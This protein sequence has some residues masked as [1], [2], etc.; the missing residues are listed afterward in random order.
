MHDEE[1]VGLAL[2]AIED[3]MSIREAARFC[4]AS[5]ESVRLWAKGRLP[6]ERRCPP[7]RSSAKPPRQPARM[8]SP[9]HEEVSPVDDDERAAYEA[10]MLENQLLRAVLADLKAGGWDPA[11]IS[12][13]RKTELGER[14]R[15]ATGLPLRAITAFLRISK[16][17]YE[18]HRARLGKVGIRDAIAD[19]VER[20][21]AEEGRSARG[22]RFVHA[23]LASE[24]GRPISEKIVRDVMRERGLEVVY[25]RTARKHSSYAGETDAGA[26][27]LPYD[28]ATGRHD[29]R[30]GAPNEKWASDVTEFNPTGDYRAFLSPVIDL[31]D[32]KPI[33]W[34]I[35]EHP[36]SKLA[37]SSLLAACATLSEGQRPFCHTDRGSLYRSNSW[38]G[39]CGRFGVVRSMSRKGRSP[40]NAAMEGFFG[41]LKN[42]FFHGRDWSGV[43]YEEFAALLDEWMRYYS[44]GRL[45]AFRVDGKVVYDTID[46]RRRQL[47][48]AA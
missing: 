15:E 28:P 38:K 17:S 44:G 41:R 12:N 6:H 16:S 9:E 31:F 48:Y 5:R 34:S 22:Y 4:G 25:G 8:A 45:K 2:L 30:A 27:N 37:D 21:F 47:G 33:A 20:I 42:E 1:T 26:P 11:S 36:D 19:D 43:G 40:D 35:S 29:F 3:G 14:L 23:V 10:A 13:R 32:G 39:I 7:G 46:N 18:Y 24:L